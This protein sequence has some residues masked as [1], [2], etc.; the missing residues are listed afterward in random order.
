LPQGK[1]GETGRSSTTLR[2]E[3][4]SLSVKDNQNTTSY[5]LHVP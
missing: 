4:R 1:A 5:F 3:Q 2:F